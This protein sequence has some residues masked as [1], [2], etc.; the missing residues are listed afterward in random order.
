MEFMVAFTF[1]NTILSDFVFLFI[2]IS[3]FVIL[4]HDFGGFRV[5]FREQDSVV[6]KSV[7]NL[8][9]IVTLFS[10]SASVCCLV[11]RFWRK[12]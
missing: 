1:W 10:K 6:Q 3:I 12:S 11:S 4:E 9:R 5:P 8:K 7:Q 2:K